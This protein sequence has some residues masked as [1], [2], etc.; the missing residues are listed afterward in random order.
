LEWELTAGWAR[1]VHFQGIG[2]A[3]V[4]VY[5]H[6]SKV[7][8]I[9]CDGMVHAQSKLTKGLLL[10]GASRDQGDCNDWDSIV[11]I[12]RWIEVASSLAW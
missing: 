6:A 8:I 3:P 2:T 10:K 12:W 11:D 4:H 7:C 9:C 5:L 1:E